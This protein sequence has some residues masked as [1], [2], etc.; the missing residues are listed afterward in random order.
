MYLHACL[1]WRSVA[2]YI[3]NLWRVDP[4]SFAATLNMICMRA[5]ALMQRLM[6]HEVD[7]ANAAIGQYG[8]MRSSAVASSGSNAEAQA[9]IVPSQQSL[10]L[11]QEQQQMT[12]LQDPNELEVRW[13]FTFYHDMVSLQP[14]DAWSDIGTCRGR[15]LTLPLKHLSWLCLWRS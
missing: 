2:Q 14:V 1:R 7:A 9:A 13:R 8:N 15:L 10:P 5:P 4:S 11:L 6:D 3:N 12:A